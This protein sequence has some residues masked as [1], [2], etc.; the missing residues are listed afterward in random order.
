MAHFIDLFSP[1]T[2]EAFARSTRAVSGFRMRHKG[3][4]ER[5]KPG[6]TFVCYLTRLLPWC[7]LLEV[8]DGPFVDDKPI[9]V[10]ESDPF[11]VRVRPTRPHNGRL[12]ACRT[13][14]T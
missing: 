2:Y 14:P 9:F 13:R 4:A 6:A 3:M 7:G 1:E 12:H 10:T 5:I 8:I 11:V